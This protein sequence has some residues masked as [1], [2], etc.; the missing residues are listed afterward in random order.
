MQTGRA[1]PRP[2]QAVR[3]ARNPSP[4]ADQFFGCHA[5]IAGNLPQENWRN[6]PAGVIWDGGSTPVGM[7]IL[8]VRA[9]LPHHR[10]AQSFEDTAHLS[11]L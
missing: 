2:L 3:S 9:S 8:Q 11:R 5:N 7:A 6:V 1:I 4:V 10:E